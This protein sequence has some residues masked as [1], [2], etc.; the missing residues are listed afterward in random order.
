MPPTGS[1]SRV[2]TVLAVLAQ[3]QREITFERLCEQVPDYKKDLDKH[4]ALGAMQDRATSRPFQSL[5]RKYE[6]DKGTLLRLGIQI[7]WREDEA[8]DYRDGPKRYESFL[9]LSRRNFFTQYQGFQAPVTHSARGLAG[10]SA[11]LRISKADADLLREAIT[12]L[13]EEIDP[14]L[15]QAAA[16]AMLKLTRGSSVPRPANA[17]AVVRARVRTNAAAQT[18]LLRALQRKKCV[19]FTYASPFKPE[20]KIRVVE[21]YGLFCGN[22]KWFLCGLDRGSGELRKF[23]LNRMDGPEVE[24]RRPNSPDYTIP[25]DFVFAD[26]AFIP[27]PWEIGGG[28]ATIVDVDVRVREAYALNTASTRGGRAD[29]ARP[30]HTTFSVKNPDPFFGWI[31]SQYP[32]LTLKNEGPLATKWLA[33]L[34]G[35]LATYT[36]P[37]TGKVMKRNVRTLSTKALR[38]DE[39]RSQDTVQQLARLAM[40]IQLFGD[41]EYHKIERVARKLRMKEADVL[42]DLVAGQEQKTEIAGHI[43]CFEIKLDADDGEVCIKVP[44]ALRDVILL[45]AT[46]S[47]AVVLGLRILR[48]ESGGE[49]L[50]AIDRMIATVQRLTARG[51]TPSERD[52]TQAAQKQPYEATRSLSMRDRGNMQ[53]LL[54]AIDQQR[55]VEMLYRSAGASSATVRVVHPYQITI[56]QTFFYVH[57][58]CTIREKVVPF[59]SDRIEALTKTTLERYT[60]DPTYDYR[61]FVHEDGRLKLQESAERLVVRFTEE[62]ARIVAEEY[63]VALDPDGGLVWSYPLLDETWAVAHVL[64]YGRQAEILS[65]PSMRERMR[66]H[67]QQL[68]HEATS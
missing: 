50:N 48:A 31:A 16:R 22:G 62:A 4:L 12:L 65:P 47:S 60:I 11:S 52:A 28:S 43:P 45:D 17:R 21:P 53:L 29:V 38:V 57:A 9:K 3:Y 55:P 33:W 20:R 37:L 63:R 24:R 25:A 19:A 2:L 30:D 54:G 66:D 5:K 36:A 26:H 8:D 40:M 44:S 46:E 34:E 68:I 56:N 42:R 13:D 58:Y 1:V 59:R 23:D 35:M 14:S 41:N 67:L 27:E 6:R 61:E 51:D 64:P 7:E 49:R 15:T 10:G 18:V 39:A 32:A